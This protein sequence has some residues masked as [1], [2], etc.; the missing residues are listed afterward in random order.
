MEGDAIR[1]GLGAV[2]NVG[3]GLIRSMAAKRA[4]SGPFKSLEDFLQRMGEG[5]LNKRAVENFIKCGALDCFGRNRSELLAVYE[6]MMD[7]VSSTRKKNLEGQMG[8]F[9]MLDDDA[10]VEIPIPRL[11]ELSKAELMAYEKET[12]GIYISGHPMDDYRALLKNT[13]VVP[14]GDLMEEESKFQDDQIVSVAGIV[15][16]AK[17]KTTR[18][19]SMMAYVTVEDDTAAIEMLA[20]SNVLS[21]YGGYL[22]ENSPV[23]ITGRLSIRDDKEPQ[24]VINRARPISDFEGGAVEEEPAPKAQAP[25]QGTLYLKIP[26]ETDALYRK[27]KAILNM[28]PGDSGVVLYFADTK[29]RRGTRC[30]LADSMLHELKKILGQGNV[31]LK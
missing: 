21:Q 3:R 22:R 19:N 7:T 2:K 6:S 25:R 30:M 29:V 31:V 26:S 15:Q 16:G 8:L 10:A 12:T 17:M 5:E 24:I 4:E 28:F 18:N 11:P 9:A 1:F 13:H 23:V 27:V 20:F 14:I